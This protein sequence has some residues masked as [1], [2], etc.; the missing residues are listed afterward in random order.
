MA[1]EAPL[2]GFNTRA[3]NRQSHL[4]RRDRAQG[5]Y[6]AERL[7]RTVRSRGVRQSDCSP[8]RILRGHEM[9]DIL[10]IGGALLVGLLL[11]IPL[12]EWQYRRADKAFERAKR[13]GRPFARRIGNH[14][15]IYMPGGHP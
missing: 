11:W 14:V 15:W 8:R 2:E 7:Y 4:H 13:E 1:S 12:R 6:A 5:D 3:A 9:T 10:I